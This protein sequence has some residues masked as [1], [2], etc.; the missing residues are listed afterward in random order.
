[1]PAPARVISGH[2]LWRSLRWWCD[3]LGQRLLLLS[4]VV[5]VVKLLCLRTSPFEFRW[6]RRRLRR[7]NPSSSSN[8][9]LRLDLRHRLSALLCCCCWRSSRRC[10]RRS[11]SRSR[12]HSR[13]RPRSAPGRPRRIWLPG[14]DSVSSSDCFGRHAC[15]GDFVD[16]ELLR[17][18]DGVVTRLSEPLASRTRRQFSCKKPGKLEFYNL[19][20]DVKEFKLTIA[21]DLFAGAD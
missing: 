13:S 1:M 6:R 3:L 10:R 14:T 9:R 15:H 7:S 12:R 16:F 2:F 18:V 5:K 21:L 17:L 20:C 4:V 19:R 11:R 8:S